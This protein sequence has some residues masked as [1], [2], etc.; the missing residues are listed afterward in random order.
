MQDVWQWANLA[1][2]FVMELVAFASLALWGWRTGESIVLE[3]VWA[4]GVP[5]LAISAWGA[6]AAPTATSDHPLLAI[7]T[8]LAVFG[9]A[10]LALWTMRYRRAAVTFV[11]VLVANLLAIGLGHLNS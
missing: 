4:I 2:A 6:F 8:K 3:V 9:G 11:V 5:V 1:L 10:A 7:A